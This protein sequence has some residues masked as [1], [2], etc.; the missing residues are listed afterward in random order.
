[1]APEL[2]KLSDKID[3]KAEANLK[4]YEKIDVWQ[5]GILIYEILVGKCPFEVI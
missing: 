1:M 3:T 4:I 5:I 2:L